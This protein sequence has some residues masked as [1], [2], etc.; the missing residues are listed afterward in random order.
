MVDSGNH[1]YDE[2]RL[3]QEKGIKKQL[4]NG[5]EILLSVSV[6][7]FNDYKKRQER[8]IMITTRSFYNLKGTDIKRK[9][10]QRKIK[11]ITVGTLGGEFVVHVPEEYDYRYASSEKRDRIL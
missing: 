6:Y 4:D 5:E 3:G 9:I 2:L 7:K 10:D 8:E 1:S 11:G